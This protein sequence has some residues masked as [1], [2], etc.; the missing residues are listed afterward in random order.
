M[1]VAMR[2]SIRVGTRAGA[3]LEEFGVAP[4]ELH[5][6]TGRDVLEDNR[7]LMACAARLIRQQ[8]SFKL[9]VTPVS[10]KGARGIVVSAASKV[11]SSKASQAISRVDVYVN[12]RPVRSIDAKKG[13][14]PSTEVSARQGAQE[15]RDR[16]S[17]G[18]EPRRED[19]SHFAGQ[20]S[21][22]FSSLPRVNLSVSDPYSPLANLQERTNERSDRRPAG[23]SRSVNPADDRPRTDARLGDRPANPAD[24]R[25]FT[26]RPAGLALP[27]PAP[28]R[29]PGLDH[30]GHGAHQRTT[31]AR[32]STR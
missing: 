24:F 15:E 6:M 32:A 5:L 31:A 7:D 28:P 12:N 30:R 3:P 8:P 21:N 19:S 10:R 27:C 17:R 20:S 1:I 23:H 26:A 25:R 18:T 13:A 2:R 9:S 4:D 16:G 29:A 22:D 11:P 14:V